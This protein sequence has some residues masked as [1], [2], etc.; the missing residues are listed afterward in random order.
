MWDLLSSGA[1]RGCE[2]REDRRDREGRHLGP[3]FDREAVRNDAR[4][5]NVHAALGLDPYLVQTLQQRQPYLWLNPRWQST[6]NMPKEPGIGFLDVAD[7]EA[8]LQ[9]FA[10]LLVTLFPALKNTGGI[11]ESPLHRVDTLQARM[12]RGRGGSGHWYLK[13]DHALPIAG[14]IKARGGFYEVLVHAERLARQAGLF[15]SGDDSVKLAG[16]EARELFAQHEI[17][18]GST[19]NLGLSIGILA[20]ALGFRATVHMSAEAKSWKKDRLRRRGVTVIEHQGDFGAAVAAGRKDAAENPSAYFVDDE[21]S[22]E[23]FL[24]YSV[25]ALRLKLQL[26]AFDVSVDATHPLFVY[27]PCGVGGAPGGITF[28]LRHVLG[29]HVHCFFAEPVA[30]PGMLLRLALEEDRAI[31][32]REIGLDNRTGA[33]GLAVAQASDFVAPLM[34]ARVSGVFTVPDNDLFEDLYQLEDTERMQIEPSAAA[35]FRGPEWILNSD[36]GR[37]YLERHALFEHRDQAA[38][39]LWTTGGSLVP[40]DEYRGF[41]ERGRGILRNQWL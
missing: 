5:R 13:A 30:C 23:L 19:G 9:R 39:L 25:A 27:L 35:G 32:V 31:S 21:H 26:E 38:H 6:A 7:A 37:E 20:A 8:R 28:G 34:R 36:A 18:V 10:P 33:D 2:R 15:A 4:V 16:A 12:M 40:E 41:H 17:A 22:R 3:A 24:G 1:T 11:I 14:S 29:D